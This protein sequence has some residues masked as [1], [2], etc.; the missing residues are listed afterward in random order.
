MLVHAKGTALG[1]A[2]SILVTDNR[3][4][5]SSIILTG[6][7][8]ANY[9]TSLSLNSHLQNGDDHTSQEDPCVAYKRIRF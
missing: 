1:S 6:L 5:I 2:P 3:V 7:L 9:L 4:G 8:C